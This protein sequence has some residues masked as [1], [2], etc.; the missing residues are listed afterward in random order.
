MDPRSSTDPR[1]KLRDLS[2]EL[3]ENGLNERIPR[4]RALSNLTRMAGAAALSLVIGGL[5]G[6]LSAHGKEEIVTET[7][8]LTSTVYETETET[9]T[10][11]QTLTSTKTVTE[12]YTTTKTERP[13]I[14]IQVQVVKGYNS[15]AKDYE[16]C[17]KVVGPELD[18]LKAC[19]EN[20]SVSGVIDRWERKTNAYYSGFLTGKEIG[21]QRIKLEV[22]KDGVRAEKDLALNVGLSEDEISQSILERDDLKLYWKDLLE[23]GELNLD[24]EEALRSENTILN[25]SSVGMYNPTISYY[26]KELLNHLAYHQRSFSQILPGLKKLAPLIL[27]NPEVVEGLSKEY[28]LRGEGAEIIAKLAMDQ[29]NGIEEYPYYFWAAAKQAES[30]CDYYRISFDKEVITGNRAL[31]KS[32]RTSVRDVWNLLL[33]NMVELDK[34]GKLYMGLKK[35]DVLKYLEGDEKKYF[36]ADNWMREKTVNI[37]IVSADLIHRRSSYDFY[38]ADVEGGCKWCNRL[39]HFEEI[40]TPSIR[41]E[42]A[43]LNIS[44][45]KKLNEEHRK[46]FLEGGVRDRDVLEVLEKRKRVYKWEVLPIDETLK[47]FNNSEIARIGIKVKEFARLGNVKL[48][49]K[50]YEDIKTLYDEFRVVYGRGILWSLG[51]PGFGLVTWFK[52]RLP[53]GQLGYVTHFNDLKLIKRLLYDNVYTN[54]VHDYVIVNPLI[55]VG[56]WEVDKVK[57]VLADCWW[58]WEYET[59]Y[60]T[61]FEAND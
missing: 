59:L 9:V 1:R 38:L 27:T 12:T 31:G 33:K 10:R 45:L 25:E 34:K 47:L 14:N 20:A 37:G 57:V 5:I 39:K 6:Y 32:V 41:L 4:R 7:E 46:L 16:V 36:K 51:I 43:L 8:T 21:E 56:K 53:D 44:N 42:F 30:F 60:K 15:T 19:Y 61:F 28:I 11:T 49:P 29:P 13:E 52:N 17:L 55:K 24:R 3:F 48:R 22:E 23:D 35:E 2:K 40:N 26:L 50:E 18:S 58:Q 54:A